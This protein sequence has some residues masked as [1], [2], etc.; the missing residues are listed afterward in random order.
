MADKIKEYMVSDKVKF[1]KDQ[2]SLLDKLIDDL[3]KK[4]NNIIKKLKN[5]KIKD[6]EVVI[7]LINYYSDK[8][9]FC[10]QALLKLYAIINSKNKNKIPYFIERWNE[11]IELLEN[12]GKFD[13]Q[14]VNVKKLKYKKVK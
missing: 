3:K 12:E 5:N 1:L 9:E 10:E 14:K 4:R 2:I 8:K 7:F 13:F 6:L 11:E